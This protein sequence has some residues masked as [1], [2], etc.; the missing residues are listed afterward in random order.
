MDSLRYWGGARMEASTASPS[1]LAPL[2]GRGGSHRA[3]IRSS[4]PSST[5]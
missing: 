5:P 1:T 4:A 2:L 3:S